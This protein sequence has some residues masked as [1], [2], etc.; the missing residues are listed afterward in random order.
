MRFESASVLRAI[1]PPSPDEEVVPSVETT[2]VEARR[3]FRR[4]AQAVRSRPTSS[5]ASFST[6]TIAS[7]HSFLVTLNA[8]SSPAPRSRAPLS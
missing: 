3:A 8:R 7:S 5:P 6:P 4:P 2:L 1:T